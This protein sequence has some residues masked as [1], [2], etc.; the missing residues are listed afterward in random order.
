M[1]EERTRS[2]LLRLPW[3]IRRPIIIDVLRYGRRFKPPSFSWELIESRVRL[4]NRFD[5]N[6]PDR[7]NFYVLRH[8]SPFLHGHGL[9]ATNRQLCDETKLL[10][11]EE[12]ESANTEIPFI[13][14]VMFVKDVG[15]FPTWTSFPYQPKHLKMLA[16]NLRIIRPGT[17]IVPDE[18]IEV[19]RYS[20]AERSRWRS[21]PAR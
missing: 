3:E 20:E 4:C 13:F 10:I 12:L 15:I 21:F 11:K 16:I 9:R 17:A 8:K 6:Y 19:A 5:D 1:V 7:T 14:D 18:W 2:P